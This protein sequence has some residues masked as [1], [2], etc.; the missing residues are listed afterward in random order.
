MMVEKAKCL[1]C[2]FRFYNQLIPYLPFQ[3]IYQVTFKAVSFWW[4]LKQAKD[5]QLCQAAVQIVLPCGLYDLANPKMIQVLVV[6]D[7]VIWTPHK[8]SVIVSP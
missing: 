2:L 5:L 4:Y 1:E 6:D 8:S 7:D 3:P